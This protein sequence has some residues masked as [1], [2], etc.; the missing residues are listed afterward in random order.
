MLFTL[1]AGNQEIDV[2]GHSHT[3]DNPVYGTAGL[4]DEQLEGMIHE[5]DMNNPIYGL[6]DEFAEDTAIYS[7]PDDA[8]FDSV[9]NNVL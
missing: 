8:Q 5:R 9:Y 7:M 2:N 6:S 1:H 4:P 3:L